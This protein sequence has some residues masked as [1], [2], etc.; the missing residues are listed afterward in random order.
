M[1][2]QQ[3]IGSLSIESLDDLERI[4]QCAQQL[5]KKAPVLIRINPDKL[6]NKFAMKMGGRATQFGIDEADVDAAIARA[7]KSQQLELLGFHVYSGTQCLDATAL[8]DN[9]SYTLEIVERYMNKH[10]LKIS[11]LNLG[12]GFGVPYFAGDTELSL[13]TLAEK[14][15]AILA[16]FEK[17]VGQ[18]P[19]YILEL[20]RYIVAEAGYYVTSIL[21]KKTSKGTAF[22]ILDGGMHQNLAA[23]GYL[24]QVIKKNYKIRNASR[25]AAEPVKVNLAGT[26]CTPLD[27]LATALE[28]PAAEIGDIIV[29]ENSGAYAFSSSPLFFLSHETPPEIAFKDGAYTLIR[30]SFKARELAAV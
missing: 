17:R 23:A 25:P 13:G 26:L 22:Y 29:F 4:E 8:L 16:D 10:S 20:G 1:A 9:Y 24:G 27:T 28:L 6:T 30:R 14:L 12:G 18:K 3:G 7:K 11:R 2:L 15:P 5:K 21:N 19:E